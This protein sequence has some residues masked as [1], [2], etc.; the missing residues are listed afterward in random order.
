[1]QALHTPVTGAACVAA[2]VLSLLRWTSEDGSWGSPSPWLLDAEPWRWFAALGLHGDWLHLAL[3]LGF[4][5]RYGRAL[6]VLAG[7]SFTLLLYLATGIFSSVAQFAFDVPGI[8]LSG[9]GFGLFAFLAVAA[10]KD[11]KYAATVQRP[12]VI[13]IAVWFLLCVA[14]TLTGVWLIGNVAHAAGALAGALLA[15][16]AFSRARRVWLV[17]L[18]SSL[19]LLSLAGLELRTRVPFGGDPQ[20][21]LFESRLALEE[22]RFEHGERLASR[23]ARN[24]PWYGEAVEML[25][26]I[27]IEAG[28]PEDAVEPLLRAIELYQQDPGQ[29]GLGRAWQNLAIAYWRSGRVDASNHAAEQARSHGFQP[30]Q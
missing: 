15:Q 17:G 25:G 23:A 18:T 21:D 5:W 16:A 7:T 12:D 2:G 28:R 30:P 22:G 19:L 14:M 24:A 26:V 20:M 8:G 9:I 11:S 4:F 1:M 6:E 3:N 13:W 10:R 27:F 29:T